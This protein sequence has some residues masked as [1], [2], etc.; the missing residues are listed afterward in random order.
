MAG[1]DIALRLKETN[2]IVDTIQY[3]LARKDMTRQ[4]KNAP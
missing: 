3:V 1:Q 2:R 4:P